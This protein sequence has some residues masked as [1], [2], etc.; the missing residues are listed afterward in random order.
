MGSDAVNG[1]T[2]GEHLIER[3]AER[4]EV[5]AR[6]DRAVHPSGL[7]GRHI[8][9]RAGDDL[10]RL[11]RLSL[12]RKP[13]GDAEAG[14]PRPVR[15]RSSPGYGRAS[16]PC[17][18]G[19]AGGPCPGP[20]RCRS[21]GAGSVPISI[22]APSSRASGSPPG[23]SSTS[24]VRPR[25]R[26]KLQRPRRPGAV[27]LVLQLVFVREPI[28]DGRRRVFRGER[29]RASTVLRLAVGAQPRSSA[30]KGVALLRQDA[31][32]LIHRR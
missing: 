15:R 9:Q 13:R 3:D 14:E 24:M 22:G 18:R 12:A 5:A 27:Q 26:T 4:I 30:E 23:S 32:A 21:R 11:G 20:R 1:R 31:K 16:D 7:F 8:G 25:S 19:R 6:I 29:A 2:P 28:E 10:G 17:G